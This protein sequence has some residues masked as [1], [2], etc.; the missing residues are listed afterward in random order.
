M[1]R[2]FAVIVPLS[3]LV[4]FQPFIALGE[5]TNEETQLIA[6]LHSDHPL[7]DKDAACA[8]L[9]WV[10]TTRCVPVL[11]GLLADAQM[12]QSACYA[13]E[14]MR[15][16]EAGNALR[17][18]LA[19]TSGSNE[20]CIIDSLAVRNETAAAPDLARLQ[21]GA[22][23]AVAAAAARALGHM[24]GPEAVSALQTGWS[25]SGA[26][27]VHQAQCDGLLACAT[28][29]SNEGDKE[30]ASKIFKGL[31]DRE[32]DDGIRLAAFRG[33]ILSAGDGGVALLVQAIGGTDAPSQGAALQLAAK[34]G[35]SATTKALTDLLPKLPMPMKIALLQS[36]AQRG[37]PSAQS[38]IVQMI[39]NPDVN[40]R[41]AAIAALGD[42]GDGSVALPLAR[43]AA[44]ATGAERSAARQSLVN[45]RH[46]PVTDPL[47][48]LL[49][50]ATPEVQTELI[51]ALGD[52]GDAAAAPEM[53]NLAAAG[54]EST[55]SAAL[56]ALAMLAG[57]AQVQPL[58]QLVVNC[59]ND[60]VRSE[61]ADVLT[62]VCQRLDSRKGQY[63]VQNLVKAV[64]TAPLDARLAL[65]GVC[66]G[67]SDPSVRDVL[68]AAA[69]DPDARVHEA[70][71]RSLCE[72]HDPALLPDLIKVACGDKENK[73]RLL[74]VK[75]CVRLTTQDDSVKLS[76]GTKLDTLKAIA[77]TSLSVPEKQLVLSGLSTVNDQR[78]LDLATPM[79]D[80]AA[81]RLE[82]AKAIIHIAES[83]SDAHP[84][85]AGAALKKI[86]A[87][88]TNPATRKSAEK[89]YKKLQ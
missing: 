67:V 54:N 77:G 10:G 85:E 53:L 43:K 49:A 20:V 3:A 1:K 48:N 66:S 73:F 70:A 52:R 50:A 78:A 17:Q 36:L 16:P 44:G 35:D 37:D 29:L 4:W 15:C 26:G 31:Y 42:L 58:I 60:D 47:L 61:V 63:D 76:V 74:A 14:S 33:E 80:D 12:T 51:R 82:A 9:K 64:Q 5:D 38:S 45:L 39:D 11:E 87:M 81:V 84:H 22:D 40:V 86:L 24:S 89:A 32:K 30:Q 25:A 41:V 69:S 59:T 56:Q 79:L 7:R 88:Q 27:A 8:R 75:G 62:S 28:R 6:V 34:V 23:P 57:P 21:T 13:L 68:R 71:L 83:V 18:A 46:G 72:T 2:F 55:R 65:L 19:K